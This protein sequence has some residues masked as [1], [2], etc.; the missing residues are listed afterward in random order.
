VFK[1]KLERIFDF[2][3]TCGQNMKR[4]IGIGRLY[5]ESCD[6]KLATQLVGGN[7]VKYGNSSPMYLCT[8]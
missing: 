2:S 5:S 6:P 3:M 8:K 7:V 4:K 1:V